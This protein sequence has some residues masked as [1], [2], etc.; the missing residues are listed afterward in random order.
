MEF[1]FIPTLLTASGIKCKNAPPIKAPA[2]KAT[3]S[4]RILFNIFS[5]KNRV[6]APT[7][8]IKL[9]ENVAMSIQMKV[10]IFFSIANFNKKPRGKLPRQLFW[11]IGDFLKQLFIKN[12]Y[13]KFLRKIYQ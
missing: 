8:A 7:K 1:S 2:E 12:P 3:R 10:V 13:L 6:R 4:R 9:I 11:K 5:F